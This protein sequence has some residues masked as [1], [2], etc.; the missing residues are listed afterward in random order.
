MLAIQATKA[1]TA[2]K[3]TTRK[4]MKATTARKRT[5]TATRKRTN[6]A[7]TMQPKFEK[8]EKCWPTVGNNG[9]YLVALENKKGWVEEVWLR[10]C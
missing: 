8:S 10:Q 6:T 9:W 1:M 3:T 4:A 7:K 5:N 2:K